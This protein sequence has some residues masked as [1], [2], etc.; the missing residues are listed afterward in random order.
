MEMVYNPQKECG[1]HGNI[2]GTPRQ[3]S[4]VAV[5]GNLILP[6]NCHGSFSGNG[7]G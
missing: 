3:S 7:K 4:A 5:S 6:H 1:Y 2:M